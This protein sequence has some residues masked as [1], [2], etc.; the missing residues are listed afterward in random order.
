MNVNPSRKIEVPISKDPKRNILDKL[1]DISDFEIAANEV[2]LAIYQRPEMTQGGILL[3]HQTLKEDIYQGKVGLVVKIGDA[4]SF[5]ITDA[6]SDTVFRLDVSLHDWVVVRPS[7]T[8]ALDLNGNS[9]VIE[10]KDFVACRL[11]RPRNIRARIQNPLVI[12]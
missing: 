9:E 5:N 6:Y 12:W 8:W 1:G 4:C 2:L 3:P 7:D 11:V 10:K